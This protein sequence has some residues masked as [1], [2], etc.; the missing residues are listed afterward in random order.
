MTFLHFCIC[1]VFMILTSSTE[2]KDKNYYIHVLPVCVF[3]V[4]PHS[5][6]K[7]GLCT[8]GKSRFA[9]RGGIDSF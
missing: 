8:E 6:N 5:R 4:P 2:G 9:C 3:K 1:I 7:P